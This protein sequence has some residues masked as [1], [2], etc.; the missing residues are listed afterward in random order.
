[1]NRSVRECSC[2]LSPIIGLIIV[3]YDAC[4]FMGRDFPI[5]LFL[6]S[7]FVFLDYSESKIFYIDDFALMDLCIFIAHC[8]K[9]LMRKSMG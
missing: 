4:A 9:R 5:Y 7:E 3:G 1:M 8:S 6:E 2:C